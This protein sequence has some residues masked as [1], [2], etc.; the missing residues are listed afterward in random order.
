MQPD[1]PLASE[2]W[3]RSVGAGLLGVSAAGGFVV[4]VLGGLESRLVWRS[5]RVVLPWGLVLGLAAAVSVVLVAG[6]RSKLH[7]LV[8]AGG[9]VLG[10]LGLLLGGPGGDYVIAADP[11]GYGYAFPGVLAAVVTATLGGRRP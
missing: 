6:R 8:A 2:T 10:L 7:G 5:G 3:R 1:G 9:W 4:A 11:L